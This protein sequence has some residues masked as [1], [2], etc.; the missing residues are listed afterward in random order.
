MATIENTLRIQDATGA[1]HLQQLEKNPEAYG[2]SKECRPHVKSLRLRRNQALH[3]EP[4]RTR[5][6]PKMEIKL[7]KEPPD[8]ADTGFQ[9]PT[10]ESMVTEEDPEEHRMETK[11]PNV[12]VMKTKL[13]KEPLDKTTGPQVSVDKSL[14]TDE[15]PEERSRR[16][17][18][19]VEAYCAALEAEYGLRRT[20]TLSSEATHLSVSSGGR[21]T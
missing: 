15:D 11:L 5:K 3:G 10:D 12:P 7:S 19:E 4:T 16:A 1:T 2:V 21:T 18:A 20:T 14:V 8:M 6:V 9:G 17:W 13:S